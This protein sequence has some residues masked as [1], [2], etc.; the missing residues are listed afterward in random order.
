MRC[1]VYMLRRGGRR[2]PWRDVQNGPS[3][4]GDLRTYH[5]GATGVGRYYY[6]AALV[7]PGDAKCTPLVPR[8]Y[9]PVLVGIGDGVISLRGFERVGTNEEPVAVVQEWY[10]VVNPIKEM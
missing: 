1:R 3:Y 8:L 5:L 2:L 4:E 10:C 7:R 9:E 6:V